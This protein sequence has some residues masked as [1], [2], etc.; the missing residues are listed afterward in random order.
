MTP[1]HFILFKLLYPL[2]ND[3]LDMTQIIATRCSIVYTKIPVKRE[4][5]VCWL[6]LNHMSMGLILFIGQQ[7]QNPHYGGY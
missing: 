5:T 7:G 2:G 3:D 6:G 4:A 1:Y